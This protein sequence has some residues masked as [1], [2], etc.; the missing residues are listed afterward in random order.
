MKYVNV[1]VYHYLD[2]YTDGLCVYQFMI[3]WARAG[4]CRDEVYDP[5]V[6]ERL[7]SWL[8]DAVKSFV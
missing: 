1:L 2:P 5:A 3:P 4:K 7:W 6:G 8:E